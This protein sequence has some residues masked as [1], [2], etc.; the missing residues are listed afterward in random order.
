MN[1]E[2]STIVQAKE[3][4][5][6]A[7][8]KA[9]G[10]DPDRL[11]IQKDESQGKVDYHEAAI[12]L[13]DDKERLF[14]LIAQ[15]EINIVHWGKSVEAQGNSVSFNIREDLTAHDGNRLAACLWLVGRALLENKGIKF[16]L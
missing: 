2:L 13:I 1:K 14:D 16:T 6:I 9:Y 10:I 11:H 3:N 4:I 8:S 12:L 7:I 5:S 15:N